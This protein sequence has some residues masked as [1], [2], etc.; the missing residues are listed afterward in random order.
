[1]NP[2]Y[3]R[4]NLGR[5]CQSAHANRP[6]VICGLRVLSEHNRTGIGLD[7]SQI[8]SKLKGDSGTG[9]TPA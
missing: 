8:I 3:A 1:M 2:C 7:R 9:G 5:S 4:S 6:L